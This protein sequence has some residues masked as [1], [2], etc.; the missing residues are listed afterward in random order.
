VKKAIEQVRN[1]KT[2]DSNSGEREKTE[3]SI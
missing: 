2:E 1:S 3:N